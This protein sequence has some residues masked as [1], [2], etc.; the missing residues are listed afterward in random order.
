MKTDRYIAEAIG[1]MWLTF[2]GC[3]TAVIAAGFPDTGVGLLGV[4]L[5]FGLS[6]VTMAYA[7]GHVSGG[8]FNPAVTLGL[9]VG[10][11]FPPG[12]VLPYMLVQVA[13]S[14]AGAYCLLL[15]AS[16]S[17]DFDLTRGFAANGYAENSPGHYSLYAGFA[18]EFLM[19]M[20]FVFIIMG[21]THRDANAQFAPLSIGLALCLIHLVSIPITNTSVNPARSTGPALIVGGWAMEQLWLFWIAPLAGGAVG[22]LICRML[23]PQHQ[24]NQRP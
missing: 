7:V 5:A 11:R 10:G 14:I 9:A 1:A 24:K 23:F 8:H 4:S 21:S 15:V 12:Q 3:G 18:A 2:T 22:G 20:V 19:T 16:G 6:V 17:A 13:G